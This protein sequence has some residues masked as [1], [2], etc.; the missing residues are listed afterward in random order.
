M[1]VGETLCSQAEGHAFAA[2]L[3]TAET[4]V[5]IHPTATSIVARV[6]RHD[7]HSCY[8][9]N[10]SSSTGYSSWQLTNTG[11]LGVDCASVTNTEWYARAANLTTSSPASGPSVSTLTYAGSISSGYMGITHMTH[12]PT[13]GVVF[14]AELDG[15]T[16]SNQLTKGKPTRGEMYLVYTGGS[17]DTLLATTEQQLQATL[18]SAEPVDPASVGGLTGASAANLESSFGSFSTMY[19]R[20]ESVSMAESYGQVAQRCPSRTTNAYVAVED[21]FLSSHPSSSLQRQALGNDTIGE[22]VLVMKPRA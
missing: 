18:E 14:G 3:S 15:R 16:L 22:M 21:E 11:P 7:T 13:L 6:Y 4:N 12:D 17:V 5:S 9:A 19:A 8:E 20:S 10:Y 2:E 1:N